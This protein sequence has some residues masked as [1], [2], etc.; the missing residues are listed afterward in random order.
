MIPWIKFTSYGDTM[1]MIPAA[2]IILVWLT[3]GRA[4]RMAIWWCLLLIAGLVL[5][6][7]TKIA[8]VGWGVGIRS[9]DFT[10]ISGHAMRATAVLPV[11]FI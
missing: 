6:A 10:G 11:I 8:F 4:W 1:V 2:F 5:V 9:I 3:V 7:A